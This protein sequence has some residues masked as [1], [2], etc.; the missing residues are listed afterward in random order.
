MWKDGSKAVD[1]ASAL[2]AE[3]WMPLDDLPPRPSIKEPPP[4]DDELYTWEMD[5]LG[6]WMIYWNGKKFVQIT[7]IGHFDNNGIA[8]WN[9][10]QVTFELIEKLRTANELDEELPVPDGWKIVPSGLPNVLLRLRST[11]ASQYVDLMPSGSLL[12][13]CTMENS[14]ADI[15][16]EV[17]EFMMDT[18]KRRCE[19]LG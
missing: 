2:N 12:G 11:T 1:L 17:T 4:L 5:D 6:R 19:A 8:L 7:S 16:I 3:W 14:A 18:F 9:G 15:P 10:S 13:G